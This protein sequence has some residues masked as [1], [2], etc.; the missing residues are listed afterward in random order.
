M[1]PEPPSPP[2][3]DAI[4]RDARE[5]L[6]PEER[7]AFLDAACAGDDALRAAVEARLDD[8]KREAAAERALAPL[9]EGP[10]DFIGR[11]RLVEKIGEGGGGVV[12]RAEQEQPVRRQ[13][14]LKVIR[15]G[16]DTAEVVARFEAE[17]QALALMEHPHIARVFDAGATPA[18]RPFFVMEWV[19]GEPINKFCDARRLFLPERLEL[20]AQV[21]QAV[22]HAHQKGVVHRDLKPSNILVAPGDDGAPAPKVI[23]FGIAKATAARLTEHTLLTS[24]DQFVGTP[25]YMSPEQAEPANLDVDTRADIY[26][27][28]VLLYELLTGRLPL[29]PEGLRAAGVDEIRRQIRE[30]DPPRPSARLA[31]LEPDELAEVAA[32]R[33]AVPARLLAAVRGDLDWIAMRCLEKDR[34]RRYDSAGDLAQDIA[35]HLAHEPVAARPP[36]KFYLLQKMVRRHRVAVAAAAAVVLALVAGFGVALRSYLSEREARTLT[37]IALARSD[38]Q[39]ALDLLDAPAGNKDPEAVA[40][41]VRALRARP[42]DQAASMLLASVLT[43]RAWAVPVASTSVS[44]PLALSARGLGQRAGQNVFPGRGF[45]PGR[46][47]P[48]QRGN[49]TPRSGRGNNQNPA[50]ADVLSPYSPL[51]L[52]DIPQDDAVRLF[53]ASGSGGTATSQPAFEPMRL[54]GNYSGSAAFKSDGRHLVT[55]A[56]EYDPENRRNWQHEETWE[57]PANPALLLEFPVPPQAG[58][59]RPQFSADGRAIILNGRAWDA[60]TGRQLASAPATNRPRPDYSPDGNRRV[61][62]NQRGPGASVVDAVSNAVLLEFAQDAGQ[63]AQAIFSPDGTRIATVTITTTGPETSTGI[64]RL[65]DAATGEPLSEPMQQGEEPL[66]VKFSPDGTRLLTFSSNTGTARVWKTATG[67]PET[68]LIA[69]EQLGASPPD[70]SPDGRWVVTQGRARVWDAATGLP[71]TLPF[72]ATSLTFSPDGLRLLAHQQEENRPLRVWPSGAAA[73]AWLPDLA[74]T[75]ARVRLDA[76]GSMEFTRGEKS[77]AE[78]KRLVA[79]EKDATQPLVVWARRVLGLDPAA[80]VSP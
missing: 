2:D 36:S 67:L 7:A 68:A 21:C 10:G 39:R 30:V 75:L 5:R 6:L 1:N 51:V 42:D 31:A 46:G 43:Q 23:D 33:G 57:L 35:R 78:L 63:I 66:R 59:Q 79:A 69:S 48:G 26:S 70:F 27:L 25:A 9:S 60:A 45:T 49:P 54:A 76:T 3:A 18:G 44:V 38:Y 47:N 65:W 56:L 14:A 41:L 15:L 12:F 4:F 52:H 34:A 16:M 20:F 58:P 40:H 32:Q 77:L 80:T 74:E 64:A 28:G 61:L 55:T 37:V 19:R 53:T 17:R 29:D 71:V 24:R 13:V 8:Y 11:Y 72:V 62:S 73:P 50:K 22:Q